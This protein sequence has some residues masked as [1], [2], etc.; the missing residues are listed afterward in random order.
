MKKLKRSALLA[1]LA[2]ATLA[3]SACA[4]NAG[5]DSSSDAA[6]SSEGKKTIALVSKGFQHQ[7]W[8]AVKAGAEEAAAELGVEVTFEGPA[9]ETEVAKQIEMLEAAINK[10]ADAIGLAALDAE[11][12]KPAMKD[13]EAKKI[14]VVMFDASCGG[15]YGQY[16]AATDNK[17]AG[18]LAAEH[19]AEAINGSGKIAII[20]HSQ[21]NSTGVDRRDGFSNYIKEKYPNI[22]IVDVQYGDGDHA[23]SADIARAMI[24]AHPDLKGIYGTNEGSAIGVVNAAKELNIDPSKLVIVGFDSGSAQI[25]AIKSGLMLGAVTQDPKSIGYLTV[26][27]AY[28]LMN[29]EKVEAFTDTGSFWYDKSNIDDEKIKGMLY[30]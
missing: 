25:E 8:Q 13:A 4:G 19:M 15:D 20:G 28:K 5:E 14:P 6:G 17:V 16:L 24:N 18:A 1:G 2:A 3:L 12:C 11:A 27:N 9:S 22:E 30:N 21:I 26:K 7:F 29:G 23:K 10:P